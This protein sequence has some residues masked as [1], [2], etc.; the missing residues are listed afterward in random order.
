MGLGRKIIEEIKRIGI[1]TLYFAVCFGVMILFKRLILEQ[2]DIQ[3]RGV[4][5]AL[6]GAL[7]L[8]KVVVLLEKVPLGEWVQRRKARRILSRPSSGS[9]RSISIT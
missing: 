5:F 9:L 7:I 3:F 8:A 1:V 6:V 2:N 4:T